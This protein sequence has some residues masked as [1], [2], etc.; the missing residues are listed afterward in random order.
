ME[1][2]HTMDA[3]PSE[4]KD[5][6]NLLAY[7]SSVMQQISDKSEASI[8]PRDVDKYSRSPILR[9]WFRTSRAVVM[10]MNSGTLQVSN[11]SLHYLIM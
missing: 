7:F 5:K 2:Y 9:Q 6:V 11:I 8:T 10:Y 1:H 4:L 3:Y